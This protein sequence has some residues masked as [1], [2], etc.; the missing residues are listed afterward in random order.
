MD[1]HALWVHTRRASG[2]GSEVVGLTKAGAAGGAGRGGGVVEL[3]LLR[4]RKKT[5]YARSHATAFW[6]LS[7]RLS[8]THGHQTWRVLAATTNGYPNTTHNVVQ[9][10]T[11]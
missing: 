5:E 4:V 9:F 10:S 6:C 7:V 2:R 1:L 3:E 8:H 11:C